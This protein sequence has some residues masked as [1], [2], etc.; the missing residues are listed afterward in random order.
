[1]DLVPFS[2]PNLQGQLALDNVTWVEVWTHLIALCGGLWF[3][4][5]DLHMSG[6]CAPLLFEACAE[7][8]ETLHFSIGG[9]TVGE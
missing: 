7:T 2:I 9:G 4:H 5:M 6:S 1:M 8:L 3:R